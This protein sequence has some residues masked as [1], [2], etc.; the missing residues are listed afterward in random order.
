KVQIGKIMQLIAQPFN[1]SLK[2][3]ILLVALARLIEKR[4]HGMS[5]G[6]RFSIHLG[7][8][9]SNECVGGVLGIQ[10]GGLEDTR[11]PARKI[12]ATTLHVLQ[13]GN[14]GDIGRRR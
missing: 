4:L 14:G 1:R 9:R 2:R 13:W 10:A 8:Q 12:G 5:E 11:E 7:L 6:L 3:S